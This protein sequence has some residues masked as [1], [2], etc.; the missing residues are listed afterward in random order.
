VWG[1]WLLRHI[2]FRWG[3]P[4]TVMGDDHGRR[5][6]AIVPFRLKVNIGESEN[7]RI[8]IVWYY[9]P[10]LMNAFSSQISEEMGCRSIEHSMSIAHR[11]RVRSWSAQKY[12]P[13]RFPSIEG[14]SSSTGS[15]PSE[16]KHPWKRPEK[17]CPNLQTRLQTTQVP[18]IEAVHLTVI[19]RSIPGR[20]GQESQGPTFHVENATFRNTLSV[21]ASPITS[22][23]VPVHRP[24]IRSLIAGIETQS[25]SP[26]PIAPCPGRLPLFNLERAKGYL[27]GWRGS[28]IK[29][30]RLV[31]TLH[32]A[33]EGF[34]LASET[35]ARTRC[36]VLDDSK[37]VTSGLDVTGSPFP[38]WVT[39][40]GGQSGG[41]NQAAVPADPIGDAGY[42]ES[43]ILHMPGFTR[44]FR[45]RSQEGIAGRE[46]RE[47]R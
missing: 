26:G 42:L 11:P 24:V 23:C 27:I 8:P 31:P 28:R 13:E 40:Q 29:S 1:Q 46:S 17:P 12:A 44:P 45:G 41:L 15:K 39:F 16:D 2:P 33:L 25:A 47:S 32:R 3:R 20:Y 10:R 34:P 22:C 5:M 36:R 4:Y 35:Q 19:R 21:N 14:I 43:C 37:A 30:S 9:T 6:S 7:R 18:N 38:G